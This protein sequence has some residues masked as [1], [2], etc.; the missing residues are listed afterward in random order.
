[1]CGAGREAEAGFASHGPH[2]IRTLTLLHL[3]ILQAHLPLM[4]H[5]LRRHFD[6]L[7]IGSDRTSRRFA[8]GHQAVATDITGAPE[9]STRP[10]SSTTDLQYAP[11][12]RIQA[13]IRLVSVLSKYSESGLLQC[14]IK[15]AILPTGS[16]NPFK[17]LKY[18][19]VSYTWGDGAK[20]DEI[21]LNGKQF[22][23]SRNLWEFLDSIRHYLNLRYQTL[24]QYDSLEVY[25]LMRKPVL[26]VNALCIN[27]GTVLERNHQIQQMGKMYYNERSVIVWLGQEE[28]METACQWLFEVDGQP[29][30]CSLYEP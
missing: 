22:M 12:D 11:L 15:H 7:T 24:G 30:H 28:S 5:S 19:S 14:E 16:K 9:Q 27:Q 18:S 8:D 1:M 21:C 26:W 4:R 6:K 10:I 13:S 3:R 2:S 29:P 20:S 17:F 25:R 23:V